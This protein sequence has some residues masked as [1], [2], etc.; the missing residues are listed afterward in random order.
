MQWFQGRSQAANRRIPPAAPSWEAGTG[1]SGRWLLLLAL[2]GVLGSLGSCDGGC[3]CG[4][5]AAAPVPPTP[6]ARLQAFADRLPSQTDMAFF[7]TEMDGVRASVS[8]LSGRFQGS[9]PVEAYRQEVR[10]V[11]GIDLLDRAS[12]EEAG[13][14]P[15]GGFCVG[16]YRE[17]PIV[18]L[19]VTDEEKFQERTLGSIA[20]YYR[21]DGPPEEATEYPG[22][23]AISDPGGVSVAWARFPDGLTGLVVTGV[24]GRKSAL[25]ADATAFELVGVQP[26]SSLGATSAFAGFRDEIGKK[27]PAS[28]YM[29]TPRLLSAYWSSSSGF[30]VAHHTNPQS[31]R[32]DTPLGQPTHLSA[33][34]NHVSTPQNKAAAPLDPTS[35]GSR[36]Q[37]VARD[38]WSAPRQPPDPPPQPPRAA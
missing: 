13:V 17:M 7:F 28:L 30:Q 9:L 21:I 22:V 31:Q 3:S 27:W 15:D 32:N 10:R 16:V 20:K 2:L 26:D 6:E 1:R 36:P 19:Y 12:Y 4:G 11:L 24:G 34:S 35:T 25:A 14:H 18:L 23:R 29:D 37:T 5:S 38:R 8:T 33:S